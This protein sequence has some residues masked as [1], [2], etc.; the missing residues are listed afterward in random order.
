MIL[1]ANTSIE[2]QCDWN[3]NFK[4]VDPEGI[5][6]HYKR[7]KW[8]ECQKHMWDLIKPAQGDPK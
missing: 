8:N 4:L 2:L 3:G 5:I 6:W 1:K 7:E